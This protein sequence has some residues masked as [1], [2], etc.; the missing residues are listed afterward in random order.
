[1]PWNSLL[2]DFR[3]LLVVPD[4]AFLGLTETLP[5]ELAN[6]LLST[7]TKDGS[8]I[9]AA[10]VDLIASLVGLFHDALIVRVFGGNAKR[11]GMSASG[12]KQT[13]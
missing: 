2:E 7:I 6:L 3:Q 1:M 13:S 9:V 11:F 5:D 10:A 4:C 8:S 12:Y